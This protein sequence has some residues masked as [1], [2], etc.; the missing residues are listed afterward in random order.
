MDPT[1]FVNDSTQSRTI[2]FKTLPTNSQSSHPRL[3]RTSP[4]T[5]HHPPAPET[6]VRWVDATVVAT[7]AGADS[8]VE[9]GRPG[10]SCL[11]DAMIRLQPRDPPSVS[12]YRVSRPSGPRNAVSRNP[13]GSCHEPALLTRIPTSDLNLGSISAALRPRGLYFGRLFSSI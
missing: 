3:C 13:N 2:S 10:M 5:L 1:K 7:G 6:T 8:P 12:P 9:S 11:G 4:H